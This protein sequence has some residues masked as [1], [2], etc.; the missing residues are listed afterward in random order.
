MAKEEYEQKDM[1]KEG[2]LEHKEGRKKNRKS[3]L[4]HAEKTRS[5][6]NHWWEWK[7]YS[8][9]GKK[10]GSYLTKLNLPLP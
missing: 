4:V 3:R 2:V 10:L 7:W 9:T 8:D 5:L 6:I 1:M